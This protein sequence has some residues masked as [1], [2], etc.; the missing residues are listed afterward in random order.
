MAPSSRSAPEPG[1]G[2]TRGILAWS[3]VS[4]ALV[5]A[6]GSAVLVGAAAVAGTVVPSVAALPVARVIVGAVA[7]LLPLAGAVV[8]YL[9]GR[10]KTT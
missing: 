8:G 6:L 1:A 2:L 4:G 7:L 10:L 9:E 5:G 3:A